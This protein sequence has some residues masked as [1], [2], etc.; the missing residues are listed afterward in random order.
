MELWRLSLRK[1]V[2]NDKCV[3]V[4]EGARVSER[5]SKPMCLWLHSIYPWASSHN[6][7]LVP[8]PSPFPWRRHISGSEGRGGAVSEQRQ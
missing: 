2:Q 4:L 7:K 5:P 8:L 6:L 3:T 1:I